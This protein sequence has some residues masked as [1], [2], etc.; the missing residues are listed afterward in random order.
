[1]AV[2]LKRLE[3][4]Q[5]DGDR[6]Y[7]VI[8]G[9]ASACC[10]EIGNLK[11][12]VQNPKSIQSV[13][14]SPSSLPPV[15]MQ[16]LAEAKLQAGDIDL[17]EADSSHE[18]GNCGAAS[19]LVSL[20]K[21]SLC[22]YQ[23]ILPD[24]HPAAAAN[25]S[26]P[27]QNRHQYWLRDRSKGP[28]RAAVTCQGFDGSCFRVV[29]EQSAQSLGDLGPSE[30]PQPLGAAKEGLF[31]IEADDGMGIQNRANQ[32]RIHA[33]KHPHVPIEGLAQTWWLE[34]PLDPKR[35]MAR[36]I[37]AGNTT[38]L[39]SLLNAAPQ[40]P[41][42]QVFY[43]STPIGPQGQV[44]FVFPGSG[45]HFSGMGRELAARWPEILRRQ[46]L[47]S[48]RL[49]S[50][51][52]PDV[53]WNGGSLLDVTD[54]RAL[55]FGQVALGTLVTDLVRSFGVQPQAVIGYSLGET[56]GL[57]ALRAWNDRDE[58]LMRMEASSLF[59][60]DLAGEYL[61]ARKTWKLDASA[62][63]DWLA[64]V[65]NCPAPK[66]RQ[67]LVGRERV[68]LL[69]INTPQESVVGGARSAVESLVR[70]LGCSFIPVSGV[71]TVHCDIVRQVESAYRELHHFSTIPPEG[72]HFYSGAWS[73][74]FQLNR[75][76]AAESILAQ[77][78][79][80]LDFPALIEQTYKDGVRIF[81]E[82]GPGSS[83]SRMIDAIL[84]DRPHMARSA[85]AAGLSEGS[86]IL[87]LLGIL[88]AER[89]PVDLEPLYGRQPA[90]EIK[91][92]DNKTPQ[93]SIPIGLK[94]FQIPL[95]PT[96][97]KA[98]GVHEPGSIGAQEFPHSAS[99]I[100]QTLSNQLTQ[101][102]A[103]A[104]SATAAAHE[105]YLRFSHNLTQVFAGYLEHQGS[106]LQNLGRPETL[107]WPDK[108]VGPTRLSPLATHYSPGVP[109]ALNRDQCLGFAVGNISHVLGPAFAEVDAFPTRVRLPDEPLMLVD[110]IVSVHG[111]P[112]SM[113]PGSVVTEHD[114]HSGA[115]Y[116]DNGRIPTCI[117]VEAGQADLFLSGY[118]GID[119]Q[120]HGRAVYRLLDAVVTFHRGLPGPG[121]VIRY[122]IRI[123]NFFRQGNT[124]FFRF[125]FDG[126]VNGQPLLT[127]REGCAG[128]FSAEEL[129]AGKGVVER[130]QNP[131]KATVPRVNVQ[132][133]PMEAATY[134]QTQVD[135]LRQGNLIGCFGPLFDGLNL[136]DPLPLPAGRMNLVQRVTCLEPQGGRFGLGLVR[137]EADIHPGD[138][139]L[140][141]HF[142]DDRVMPGTLM[143]ECCLHTVRI[144]LMRM[145]WVAEQ[146]E[147]AWEPIPGVA[148]R[149]KCR[150]QVIESTKTVTYEVFIKEL[151]FRPEP[152][153][154]ADALMYADGKAIVEI[155]DMALQLS[156][157]TKEKLQGLWQFVGW[158]ESSRPTFRDP[159]KQVNLEDSAHPPVASLTTPH[160]PS[161]DHSRILAFAIGKPSD[162]FGERYRVFDET[163]F[164]ARLPGPP[165]QFLDRITSI[166]AEPF[167]M[168][169][170]G[171]IEAQYDVPPDAWYFEANRQPRMPFA[172][173]LEV[174]L[175][176]CGWMA[177]YMG[178]ALTSSEDL[179]FR[180]LGGK[181]VPLAEITPATGAL[182]TKVKVTK[183]S[184]SAGMI[185]QNF[186][187][188][189]R[190]NDRP[191][192]RGDTY[193]GFFTRESLRQQVGVRDATLFQ[194][195]DAD[196]TN[197]K[198]MI[199]PPDAPFPD[200][201]LRMA[202]RID[203][204]LSSG[205]P[206]GFGL[207]QGS[208]KVDPNEWF[209]KAHFYQD[210]VW[211]GS[212]G[213]ESLV[214]LLKLAA[215]E[216]WG[217]DPATVFQTVV[218][219]KEHAWLYRGQVLPTNR[220]V[221]IQAEVTAVDDAGRRIEADGFLSAD[222]RIIY[223]MT[224]FSV[225]LSTGTS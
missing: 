9:I 88:I 140:T 202:D 224:N 211:P 27:L 165:Y 50:Q 15:L 206:K 158:A 94:P 167:E 37:I 108:S 101:Q 189:V 201:R 185:I 214:Q 93:V 136:H 173:L 5:R 112:R 59:S 99:P 205:G 179:C 21:A 157:M 74:R 48:E 123:E 65:I 47:E 213:L 45:N 104:R 82:M 204:Y 85:C 176:P 20:A 16:A 63:V 100:N 125:W 75:E 117:A 24:R 49:R 7:A 175:Q 3:D 102:L 143:Y 98:N 33:Q 152:F 203:L 1:V 22:L 51:Y 34:N 115:W 103:S 72:V 159:E 177:A 142:V 109:V 8:K 221:S 131:Q 153:A 154:I 121:E 113:Q 130:P 149:L 162:A 219:G 187:F 53:F 25:S 183:V 150:G 106:A 193:F 57:F 172:V 69:I 197:G 166:Q 79:A 163:R 225:G 220:Q 222:G 71:S 134:D 84:G 70:E 91:H 64:G 126:T 194:V 67:A 182:T 2:V 192:Y 81:L 80:P 54:P 78:M 114:I 10:G 30:R 151:G 60:R 95:A 76:T 32:L 128:F 144:F 119:F 13:S 145:G 170:G 120:T 92:K 105:A 38:E 148:S 160:S 124:W 215:A 129:A 168:K 133:V 207:I 180:N 210:P 132:F 39:V 155:T 209:F 137:A 89:V 46:D 86:Q 12:E 218:L 216:R 96:A 111:E 52:L 135:C 169:A 161:F 164:I 178:S 116:L 28:R 31:V 35:K 6:V 55:I 66:V 42:D 141:C 174:A 62:S 87:R 17:F 200:P 19:G 195:T 41:N 156:G 4:A 122:D 90:T 188:E 44:G 68:Y 40:T 83:C 190:A 107:A 18:V 14:H 138:W 118:L 212:L 36:T 43:S 139:F 26:I 171:V 181:A 23:E 127:M 97:K 61:A 58:M 77:A 110:R 146:S 184:S 223:H 198:V 147:A 29:L 186:E 11:S 56:T 199:Y 73:R 208:K 217:V 191:V 196:R